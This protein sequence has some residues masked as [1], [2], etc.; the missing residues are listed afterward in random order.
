MRSIHAILLASIRFY[1]VLAYIFIETV[2]S[3]QIMTDT[4]FTVSDPV[5]FFSKAKHI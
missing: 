4:P 1:K 2:S 3:N 5:V